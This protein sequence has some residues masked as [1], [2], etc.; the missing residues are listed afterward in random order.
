MTAKLRPRYGWRAS[1]ATERRSVLADWSIKHVSWPR[2]IVTDSFRNLSSCP[3]TS[4]FVW[5]FPAVRSCVY[6]R[7]ECVVLRIQHRVCLGWATTGKR[8]R[9][10]NR[11]VLGPAKQ[12]PEVCGRCQERY[13]LLYDHPE[14]ARVR[15]VAESVGKPVASP[16]VQCMVAALL[17]VCLRHYPEDS[18]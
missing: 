12:S 11:Q 15:E 13:P 18:W 1:T 3:A 7:R 2:L 8:G 9:R 6:Y 10:S 4:L 16:N 5:G 17:Y 14:K